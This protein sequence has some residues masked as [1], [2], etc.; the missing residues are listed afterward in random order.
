M[1]IYSDSM[2]SYLLLTYCVLPELTKL[3]FRGTS[4]A[5]EEIDYEGEYNGYEVDDKKIRFLR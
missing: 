5:C 2:F 3:L 1:R 4:L